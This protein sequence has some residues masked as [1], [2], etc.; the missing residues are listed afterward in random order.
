VDNSLEKE[1]AELKT[2]TGNIDRL[3]PLVLKIVREQANIQWKKLGSK[4]P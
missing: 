3:G 4:K 1:V 2:L